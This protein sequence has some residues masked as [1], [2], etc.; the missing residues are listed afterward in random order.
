M[1]PSPNASGSA[2][3]TKRPSAEIEGW[4]GWTF[5]EAGAANRVVPVLR[6]RTKIPETPLGSRLVA[7]DTKATN[8]PSA[9]SEGLPLSSFAGSPDE[10]TLTRVVFA[11]A[12]RAIGVTPR[13]RARAPTDARTRRMAVAFL[14][15]GAT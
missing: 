6:S 1:L 9:D 14:I 3:A 13:A 12:A 4:M 2:K 11:L 10:L 8:R 15:I 5:P 7:K